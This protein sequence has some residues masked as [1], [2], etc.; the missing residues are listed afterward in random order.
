MCERRASQEP[1][2]FFLVSPV[3]N[4]HLLTIFPEIFES[5]IKT[6]LIGKAI[7][8]KLLSVSLSDI[9]DFSRPPH[10]KVDDAP[11]GGG[12]G[13]VMMAQPIVEAVESVKQKEP[14][15]WVVLL[16]PSGER[17]SQQK[18]IELSQRPSVTF[19]CGR[20]EGIDHRVTELVVNEEL[21]VG[22]F[23]VMGGE[24][25]AMLI[26]EACVRLITDCP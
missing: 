3:W 8:R 2:A 21:S 9:R 14:A 18:A 16:S 11:Y 26:M 17:F 7:E 1:A 20:Y 13:M 25:P 23:V 5:F 4:V 15:S 22:D 12:A 10:N 6:S 24:V 19:I